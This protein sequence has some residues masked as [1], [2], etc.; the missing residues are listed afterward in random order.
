MSLSTR[1]VLVLVAV[2]A[3]YGLLVGATF[4]REA[5]ERE[6]L[7]LQRVSAGLARHVVEHWPQV[8]AAP[9]G[10]ALPPGRQVLLQMLMTVNPGVQV[11]LL[12]GQGRVADYLGQ[13]GMVRTHQVDLAPVRRF[14]EGAALPLRG[15]D[16][17]G[18]GEGRLFSVAPLAGGAPG[19]LYIVLDG[20]ARQRA[21]EAGAGGFWQSAAAVA[22]LGLTLAAGIGALSFRLLSRPLRALAL[23]M[24]PA[25]GADAAAR[26]GNEIALLER[27]FGR[28]T[29]RLHSQAAEERA[30]AAAHRETMAG[31]AHD[32][33]TPL[34][35]LHGLLE[36][37]QGGDGAPPARLIGA[38][39]SQSNR[40][41]RLTQ[42]LFEL[43]ALQSA[44]EVAQ[45]ECFRLDELV[46]DTVGRFRLMPRD[47]GVPDVELAAE[48]PGALEVRGDLQLVE[49]A[50]GN[51]ID[52][53]RRHGR[54]AGPVTISLAADGADVRVLV[55][56]RGPGLPDDLQQRLQEGLSPREP[57]RRRGSG[58][59]IGGLGLAIA[60]RVA[61]LHGGSLRPL[62]APQGGACLCLTL[63]RAQ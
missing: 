32:L 7:A 11:Y 39:L 24:E 46:A 4:H 18:S 10:G 41:R 15:T 19:Y 57:L 60:Q 59:G 20:S 29:A 61:Q 13:P 6:A 31:L 48:S 16:P 42:Q 53:A 14:L 22:L 36:A 58:G 12:D 9:A 38:A 43:A 25:D 52:N 55:Q 45:R 49:R 40:V 21:G 3:G 37:L 34:T 23:R 33:R 2:L 54:G 17:M 47:T 5:A 63:P 26:P 44:T 35:A 8:E 62:P 1:L 50:L 27:A 30:Q 56:D 51:L 28:M